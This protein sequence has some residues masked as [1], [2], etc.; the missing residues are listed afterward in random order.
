MKR[1]HVFVSGR[2]Q[3][4][5]FRGECE[6]VARSL[7]LTGHVGNLPDGRVEA[8]FE[9]LDADVD[10]AVAWCRE[11]PA[12]ASVERVEATAEPPEGETGFRV[13]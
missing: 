4:V 6:R 2:V 1:V 7:G 10:T 5:F 12:L 8:V 9:G 3:G 11:G 13:R